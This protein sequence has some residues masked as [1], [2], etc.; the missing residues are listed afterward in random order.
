MANRPQHVA[1]FLATQRLGAVAVSFNF[2]LPADDIDYH[3]ADSAPS[4]FLFD[5]LSREAV[6]RAESNGGLECDAC[7]HVG[8]DTP[9]FAES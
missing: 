6:E 7:V 5:G 8:D 9:A 3:L 1:T 4:V 2:R